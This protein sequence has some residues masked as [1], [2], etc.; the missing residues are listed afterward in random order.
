MEHYR[1]L[2]TAK[3]EAAKWRWQVMRRNPVAYVRG[4]ISHPDHATICLDGWHR[5][6]VNTESQ[7][8]SVAFLD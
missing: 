3:P 4:R 8:S 5:V 1:K 7:S 2:L 6:A